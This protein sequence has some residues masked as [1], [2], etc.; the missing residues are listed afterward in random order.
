MPTL[1]RTDRD[2]AIILDATTGRL[3]GTTSDPE[4]IGHVRQYPDEFITW[5]RV[6]LVRM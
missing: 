3:S 4:V 5:E 6:S 1:P 2:R